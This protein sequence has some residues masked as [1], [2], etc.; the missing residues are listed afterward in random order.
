[1][2]YTPVRTTTTTPPSVAI[3]AQVIHAEGGLSS[4]AT[5]DHLQVHSCSFTVCTAS[6]LLN[7]LV[8]PWRVVQVVSCFSCAVL[9]FLVRTW[10]GLA[11]ANGIKSPSISMP[12]P[13]SQ[14]ALWGARV[15]PQVSLPW[16]L[17]SCSPFVASVY[18]AVVA[19]VLG[20]AGC[21]LPSASATVQELHADVAGYGDLADIVGLARGQK[22]SLQHSV[23]REILCFCLLVGFAA[24]GAVAAG[25]HH[26]ILCDWR[27]DADVAFVGGLA[28]PARC[29]ACPVFPAPCVCC[30]GCLVAVVCH[31]SCI[32]GFW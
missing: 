20:H 3:V 12:S 24:S 19:D 6:C 31:S 17:P 1:M 5:A 13:Y 9:P 10:S 25:W 15:V 2:L 18:D 8:I 21:V 11:H 32:A 28:R 4:A 14:C 27:C 26:W 16:S 23:Y 22:C 30:V 7:M 29:V